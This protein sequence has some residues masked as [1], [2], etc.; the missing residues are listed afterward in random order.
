MADAPRT[1]LFLVGDGMGDWPLDELGGKTVLEAARTP[2]M[3]RL[4]SLGLTGLCRTV[5][6]SMPPGSDVAN[7]ALMG[8]DPVVH[9]TGRGPIEAAAQGLELDQDDLV[10]RLNL[11][12][13]S[14]FSAHG[15]MR[16]YSAGHIDTAE[17]TTL[18]DMIAGKLA[19][20]LGDEFTIFP[21]VQYRHLL[22]AK[23]AADGPLEDLFIHPPHDILDKSIK[24]DVEAYAE[25]PELHAL[26]AKAANLLAAPENTTKANALWPWGQGRPLTLPPFSK[27]YG[28]RGAV[29][30]AV[31]LVKGLGRAA[32]MD[33]LEVE[34]VTGLLDTNYEGKVQ[35][36][37]DFI[38]GGGEFV[39][40]HVEAPDECG[41]GGNAA[42]KIE[43]IE[44]FDARVV[45]PLM[46][47]LW[48]RNA[49]FLVGCDHFTPVVERTHTKD[50]VPFAL[51]WKDCETPSGV[52]GYS[53]VQA[54]TTGLMIDPGFE[55]LGWALAEA[56][57][58]SRK[59]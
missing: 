4:A 12:T 42:E 5:P 23:G 34:G 7:M 26:L 19:D 13:V 30:S 56:G 21:G 57:L 31:D 35:A 20:Q 6:D 33:V 28:V 14:E 40:L 41:H 55:L 3:D 45:G 8:F 24:A 54:A 1:F 29:I 44:R 22:V 25:H 39:F 2:H 48:E 17:A 37:L 9:H 52:A 36:A 51:A 38:D 53:E 43:A 50:P 27:T 59:K 11:V 15:A 32:G 46:D 49:A 16:D 58:R 47:A 18:L 10:F